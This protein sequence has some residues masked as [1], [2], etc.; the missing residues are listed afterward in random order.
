MPAYA[1]WSSKLAR[2]VFVACLFAT[3]GCRGTP[4]ADAA[5]DAG[6][7]AC[8]L[9]AVSFEVRSPD[10]SYHAAPTEA[11]L[12]LGFQGFRYI[13]VRVRTDGTPRPLFG[14]V[15]GKLDGGEIISQSFRLDLTPDG[16]GRYM[17]E[18]VM[19]LFGDWPATAL[20]DHDADLTVTVGDGTCVA[21][22]GGTVTLRFDPSCY[23]GPTGMRIC[24]D[25]GLPAADDGGLLPLPDGGA[26]MTADGGV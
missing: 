6:D 5:P 23:E 17:T 7:D 12:V 21:D 8:D 24:P 10:G 22:T 4:P 3:A 25:G 19:V 1:A 9:T 13:Y 20:I 26:A 16:P 18:P 2:L 11:E 15:N 14:S